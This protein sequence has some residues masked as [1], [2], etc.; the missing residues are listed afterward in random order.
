MPFL[1]NKKCPEFC[2]ISSS[3]QKIK[4]KVVSKQSKTEKAT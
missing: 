2:S 4:I 1:A 3:K